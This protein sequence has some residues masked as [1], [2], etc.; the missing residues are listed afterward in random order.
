MSKVQVIKKVQ[1]GTKAFREL[2]F[3]NRQKAKQEGRK[4]FSVGP[5]KKYSCYKK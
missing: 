1:K 3:K 2:F 4:T 5:F